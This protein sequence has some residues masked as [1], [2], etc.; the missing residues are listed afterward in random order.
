MAL[1][2]A[3]LPMTSAH[4]SSTWSST[5]LVGVKASKAQLTAGQRVVFS[6]TVRP[7]GAAAGQEVVL[8]E[9][10]K[11]G[12]PWENQR[13][14]TI[15]KSGQY[16]ISDRPTTNTR[17]AYRVVMP[18]TSRHA[19]GV[20]PTVKVRVY[21]WSALIN[22]E[23]VNRRCISIGDVKMNGAKYA[24]SLYA[25]CGYDA[26]LE[27]NLD[28]QCIRLRATFGISDRSTTAG[29]AEVDVESD[30]TSVYTHTFDIGKTEAKGVALD[31][32]LKLRLAAHSTST[33]PVTGLGA[34]G[35]PEVLCTR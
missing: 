21:A 25:S 12:K 7:H 1:G 3:I 29:Q 19:K 20:S 17:H 18:A 22:H 16:R 34:F 33:Y 8:Q 5:W 13:K 11:P 2:L 35:T 4:A 9:R 26:H 32:P 27:F 31:S 24:K 14:A 28:H 30:G 6:G 15:N 10:F 23:S